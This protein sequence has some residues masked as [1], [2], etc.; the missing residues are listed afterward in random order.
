M[1]DPGVS[2]EAT[3]RTSSYSGGQ[4]GDCIQV[5]P[6]PRGV[7]VRDSKDTPGPVLS[8]PHEAWL[9]FVAGLKG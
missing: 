5:A 6:R 4:G 7:A 3:W 2:I 9:G 1:T 8:F